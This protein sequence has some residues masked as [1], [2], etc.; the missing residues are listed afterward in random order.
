MPH[1][2][3]RLRSWGDNVGDECPAG[4][5]SHSS[6]PHL[7]NV[8]LKVPCYKIFTLPMFSN[9]NHVSGLS[10]NSPKIRKAHPLLILPS[11]PFRKTQ[12]W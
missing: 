7:I 6:R 11:L 2:D 4:A 9:N 3:A 8:Y 1:N 10:M 12:F 5:I